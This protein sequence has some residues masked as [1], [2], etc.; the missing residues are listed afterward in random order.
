MASKHNA[1]D[2]ALVDSGAQIPALYALWAIQRTAYSLVS[3]QASPHWLTQPTAEAAVTTRQATRTTACVGCAMVLRSNSAHRLKCSLSLT[4]GLLVRVARRVIPTPTM[5]GRLMK[6]CMILS[7][8][9]DLRVPPAWQI[10][11]SCT[12]NVPSGSAATPVRMRIGFKHLQSHLR[13]APHVL[14]PETR[15]DCV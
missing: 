9:E 6:T 10:D 4:T 11:G 1:V 14:G 13:L 3:R 5:A 2:W 15:C 8:L 7:R 12:N